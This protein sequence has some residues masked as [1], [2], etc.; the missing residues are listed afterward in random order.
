MVAFDKAM[1]NASD[2]AKS[3]AKNAKGSVVEIEAIPKV[4]RAAAA[5]MKLLSVA[6]NVVGTVIISTLITGIT[7]MIGTSE[8]MSQQAAEAT[9]KYKEQSSSIDEYKDKIIELRTSLD[10]E[11]LSYTDAKDKRS[12][13]IEIQ[14]QLID[15]YGDEANNIVFFKFMSSYSFNRFH[16]LKFSS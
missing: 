9:E 16:S 8:E 7:K 11:N 15:T 3:L 10:T 5:G 6:M 12:Q 2:T 13:L 1:G 14:K 4:S